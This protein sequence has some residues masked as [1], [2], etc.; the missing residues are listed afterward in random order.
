MQIGEDPLGRGADVPTMDEAGLPG[1]YIRSG[2]FSGRPA[3]G[4][5]IGKLNAAVAALPIRRYASGSST[6]GRR[7]RRATSRTP[8]ASALSKAEIE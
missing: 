1:L 6:P 7:F 4:D 3:R 2:T 8:Q 5:V